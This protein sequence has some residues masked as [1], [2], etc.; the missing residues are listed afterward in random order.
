MNGDIALAGYVLTMQEWQEL[1]PAS[2]AQLVAAVLRW[3]DPCDA[4]STVLAEGSERFER[5]ESPGRI[6]SQGERP[7]R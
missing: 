5:S 6:A 3:A 1:D 2:R 4:P 7:V